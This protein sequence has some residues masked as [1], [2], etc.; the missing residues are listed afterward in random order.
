MKNM[1]A[2]LMTAAIIMTIVATAPAGASD[3]L[4]T[5]QMVQLSGI[6]DTPYLA[7]F[8]GKIKSA[9]ALARRR[10]DG[11]IW[12]SISFWT[13]YRTTQVL[14][15]YKGTLKQCGWD[16]DN[17]GFSSVYAHHGPNLSTNVTVTSMGRTWSHVELTYAINS[18]TF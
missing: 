10:A 11:G 18:K 16:S 6:P 7:R 14:D 5:N 8:A 9:K 4:N 17:V 12:Y 15:W 13:P 1:V 2:K 3:P